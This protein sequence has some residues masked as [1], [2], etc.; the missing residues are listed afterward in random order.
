MCT[1]ST[2]R[3]CITKEMKKRIITITEAAEEQQ[4]KIAKATKPKVKQMLQSHLVTTYLESYIDLEARPEPIAIILC[5]EEY[6]SPKVFREMDVMNESIRKAFPEVKNV[7]VY[8][9]DAFIQE[10]EGTGK[11]FPKSTVIERRDLTDNRV[12]LRTNLSN[13]ERD[14]A[15]DLIE[16]EVQRNK[17]PYGISD[18]DLNLE[19]GEI[20]IIIEL[21]SEIAKQEP[22]WEQYL[23]TKREGES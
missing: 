19:A 7:T 17:I 8:G 23:P 9:R 3:G 14:N 5:T 11:P 18:G 21:D 1:S 10:W 4:L 16:S 13:A 12:D 15:S 20:R 22:G 2:R 6:A